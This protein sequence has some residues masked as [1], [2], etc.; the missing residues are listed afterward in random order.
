MLS[1]LAAMRP[2]VLH[3][4]NANPQMIDERRTELFVKYLTPGST[5][6]M[7]IESFDPRVTAANNLNCPY[8]MAFEAIRTVNRIGGFRGEN[9]CH[10]L[11]PGINILLGLAAET[12]ETLDK[13]FAALKRIMDEGLLIR[14]INIR[15]VVPFPGTPL[16]QQV[17]RKFLRKNMRYYVD[18]IEKVR[19]EIDIPMLQRLFPGRDGAQ[20]PVQRGPQRPHDLPAADRQLPD[21]RGRPRAAAAERALRRPRH[22]LHAPQPRR[23]TSDMRSPRWVFARACGWLHGGINAFCPG[24]VTWM[25][26]DAS[27]PPG[28]FVSLDRSPEI[29]SC[30]PRFQQNFPRT[31]P[32][33]RVLGRT[34]ACRTATP[35]DAGEEATNPASGPRSSISDFDP[36]R[37]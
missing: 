21:R 7:G 29:T 32:T 37:L 1:R 33:A 9:G 22:R 17:G 24:S 31:P 18:W 12:P 2:A 27:W 15:R 30:V 11:L 36:W 35:S 8:D 16:Y 3:I 10:A 20:G 28:R 23:R 13:N 14:R 6:A 5:A 19:Q 34:L 4:D 26:I 25:T